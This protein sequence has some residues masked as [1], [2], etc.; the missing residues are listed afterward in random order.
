M[1]FL[2]IEVN[3]I[4]KYHPNEDKYLPFMDEMALFRKTFLES[5]SWKKMLKCLLQPMATP[6]YDYKQQSYV[7]WIAINLF[8][9]DTHTLN[10]PPKFN[11]LPLE[12]DVWSQRSGFL[13]GFGISFQRRSVK[14]WE[15]ST[16]FPFP[17]TSPWL[18]PRFFG[19]RFHANQVPRE[20]VPR[21][22]LYLM[23]ST[24]PQKNNFSLYWLYNRDAYNG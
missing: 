7:F 17:T 11:S 14:L 6:K 21:G 19:P 4:K 22:R 3:F 9:T 16:S 8:H 13:L 23:K 5:S 20:Q 2:Y 10:T 18:F 15:D 1:F 24:E 12:V